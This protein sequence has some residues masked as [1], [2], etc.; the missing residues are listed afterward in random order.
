VAGA[1]LAFVNIMVDLLIAKAVKCFTVGRV[2]DQISGAV[3]VQRP[4]TKN[5]L[6]GH[7]RG[8]GL[9][10]SLELSNKIAMYELHIRDACII[11]G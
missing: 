6:A 5:A 8:R 7:D 10:R 3:T 9:Q 2:S 11:V 4:A 1:I